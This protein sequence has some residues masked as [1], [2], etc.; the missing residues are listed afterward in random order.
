MS[1]RQHIL[2]TFIAVLTIIGFTGCC[3]SKDTV[4]T[5]SEINTVKVLVAKRDLP[6]GTI[7]TIDDLAVA[8]FPQTQIH[9]GQCY[10]ENQAPEVLKKRLAIQ[11]MRGEML[12]PSHMKK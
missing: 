11:I 9:E 12:T 8:G 10:F 1:T 4:Q 6:E 3:T 5:S 2:T 7:L